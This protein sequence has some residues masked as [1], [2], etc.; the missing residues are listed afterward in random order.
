[1]TLPCH[2]Y[3]AFLAPAGGAWTV[4][5]KIQQTLKCDP[6]LVKYSLALCHGTRISMAKAPA[7]QR[8]K[9]SAGSAGDLGS[10]PG[11]GR[12]PGEGNGNPRQYSCLG[13]PMD[14]EPGRLQSKGSQRVGR[15]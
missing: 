6:S 3:S 4:S 1:M 2:L 14:E 11:S 15:D 8:I 5:V 9:A 13:N 10:S 12:F 7:A